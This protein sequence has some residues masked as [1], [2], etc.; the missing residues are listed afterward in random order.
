MSWI[1]RASNL[2]RAAFD[3]IGQDLRYASRLLPRNPGFAAVAIPSPALGIGANAAVFSLLN[4]VALRNLDV[5]RPN[6]LVS[7]TPILRNGTSSYVSSPMFEALAREQRVFSSLVGEWGGAILNVDAN[8]MRLPGAVWA[9]TGNFHS[10]LD[11]VPHAGRLL[12]DADVNLDTRQ[13]QMVAVIGYGLWLRLFGGDL[14]IIG[15]TVKVDDVPFTIVGIGPKG[16]TAFGTYVEPDVTIPLT[17][18]PSVRRDTAVGLTI[19]KRCGWTSW[20]G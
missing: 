3:G 11:A 4:A 16:F 15:R 2:W 18:L 8:G 19:Q 17:S 7:V 10:V 9:V 1:T 12:T 20:A 14:S 5:R 13:P 6:Q